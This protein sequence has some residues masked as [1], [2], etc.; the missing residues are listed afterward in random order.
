M[1]SI[2]LSTDINFTLLP[3]ATRE[4]KRLWVQIHASYM[5]HFRTGTFA[6]LSVHTLTFN[7]N[8]T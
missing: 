5:Q 8:V 3:E 6:Y 7:L 1:C 4:N 2:A